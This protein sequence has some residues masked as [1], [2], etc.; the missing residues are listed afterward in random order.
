LGRVE[1][2]RLAALE[3]RAREAASR[4]GTNRLSDEDLEILTPWGARA[5]E[6]D[7]AGVSRPLPTPEQARAIE[8]WSA[9]I[10]RAYHEGWGRTD[11]HDYLG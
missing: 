2:R 9:E 11:A 10:D 1:D 8:R 3:R 6:A 7:A 5:L 4:V